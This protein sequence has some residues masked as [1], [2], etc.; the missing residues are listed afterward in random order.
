MAK[1][2]LVVLMLCICTVL[3]DMYLQNP[4]GCND[5]LDEE[6]D[7]QNAN[8]LFDSENNARGGYCWYLSLSFFLLKYVFLFYNIFVRHFHDNEV[9]IFIFVFKGVLLC[10]LLRVL[11]CQFSGLHNMVSL[12]S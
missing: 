3:G 11:Y 12:T 1:V 7:R 2:I 6:T 5:R 10:L 9:E 8:R 4:R